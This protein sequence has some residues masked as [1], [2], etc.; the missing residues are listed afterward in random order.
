MIKRNGQ[1]CQHN[2]PDY[3]GRLTD[4]EFIAYNKVFP[5]IEDSFNHFSIATNSVKTVE[6]SLPRLID[7]RLSLFDNEEVTTIQQ[8]E[9]QWQIIEPLVKNPRTELLFC[10]RNVEGK[11]EFAII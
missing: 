4:A 7:S 2:V 3:P 11:D 8:H 10:K 1:L 9:T 5:L 6:N